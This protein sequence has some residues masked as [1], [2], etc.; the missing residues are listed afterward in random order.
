MEVLRGVREF[1]QINGVDYATPDGS[2]I[3]D[4]VHVVDLARAHVVALAYAA[5]H[6]GAHTYNVGTG[7]GFSVKE[8]VAAFASAAGR[9]I[10]LHVGARRPGDLPV[11]VADVSKIERELGWHTEFSV[12]DMASSAVQWI[13]K[14]PQGFET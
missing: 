14:N 11:V 9:E 5:A 2:C 1:L 8:I 3:R 12:T 10:P 13:T 4:Y 7:H 6:V